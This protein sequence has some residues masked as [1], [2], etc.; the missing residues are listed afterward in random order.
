MWLVVPKS[1]ERMWLNP[2]LDALVVQFFRTRR[3]ALG[4]RANVQALRTRNLVARLFGWVAFAA[5]G[6][7]AEGRN[8]ASM[9]PR[10]VIRR[11]THPPHY[12]ARLTMMQGR[13]FL[14]A[15]EKR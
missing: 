10:R 4:A 8:A 7:R 11:V 2:W 15:V 9:V 12:K 13:P 1:V 3:K 14:K 6:R 5:H